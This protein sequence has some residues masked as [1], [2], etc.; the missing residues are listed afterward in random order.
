MVGMVPV[1]VVD[2]VPAVAVSG[3]QAERSPDRTA[4]RPMVDPGP[5]G[6]RQVDRSGRRAG[7]ASSLI[8]V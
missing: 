8:P 2:K 1:L 3:R 6:K 4:V 5:A 7:A